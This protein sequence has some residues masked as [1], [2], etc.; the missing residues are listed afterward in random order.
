M[1]ALHYSTHCYIVNVDALFPIPPPIRINRVLPLASKEA[2]SI[3]LKSLPSN[4]GGTEL[5][6]RSRLEGMGAEV[7]PEYRNTA[8]AETRSLRRH[9]DVASQL[10]RSRR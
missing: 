7:A 9:C 6:L 2:A 4:T 3:S 5:P 10:H 8:V 1:V